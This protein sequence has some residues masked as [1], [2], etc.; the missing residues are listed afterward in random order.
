MPANT[1]ARVGTHLETSSRMQ[2][3]VLTPAVVDSVAQS[4]T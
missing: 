4:Q 3:M 2:L 1:A